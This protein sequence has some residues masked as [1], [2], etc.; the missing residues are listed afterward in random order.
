MDNGAKKELVAYCGLYCGACGRYRKGKCPGC[1]K[2]EKAAWCSVR[3]C[4]IA[5]GHDSCADC[6][7]FSDQMECAKFNNLFS[8]IFRLIFG[9]D[10]MA[11]LGRIKEIGYAGYAEEMESKGARTVKRK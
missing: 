2:N 1:R 8:K 6:R 4:G 5:N 10:R 7:L 9:S 3:Q 11:C